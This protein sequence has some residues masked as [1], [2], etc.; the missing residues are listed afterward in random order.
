MRL[1][2]FLE[3]RMGGMRDCRMLRTFTTLETVLSYY[4]SQR[5]SANQALNMSINALF[6]DWLFRFMKNAN[7]SISSFN[8]LKGMVTGDA[9]DS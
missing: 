2:D 5:C 3:D 1:R 9:I 4:L 8:Q 6:K 7:H